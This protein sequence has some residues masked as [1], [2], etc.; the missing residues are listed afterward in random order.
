MK[1]AVILSLLATL[2]FAS[3][4]QADR[5]ED[6]QI[7]RNNHQTKQIKRV[8]KRHYVRPQRRV[9]HRPHR[10][11]TYTRR[12]NHV[13]LNH[14]M[15]HRIHRLHR[16]AFRLSVGGLGY[17]YQG[18]AF[19]RPYRGGFRVVLAPIGAIIHTLPTGYVSMHINNR[20]YYRY[21]DTYYEPRGTSYCVVETPT[22]YV[23]SASNSCGTNNYQTSYQY[24]IGDIAYNLPDG[25]MEVII[26]G[27]SYFEAD[28][29]YFLRSWRD[30]I[31]VYEVVR[32]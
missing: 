6:R 8:D 31:N 15:G 19:Y 17:H 16:N 24:Q 3:S 27:R 28:G 11:T 21:E 7:K 23:Q 29:R 2:V 30:G 14:R 4:A 25:A 5:W 9:I 10:T 26:D 20:N 1:K 12:P 32:L 22:Q 13:G 18:G